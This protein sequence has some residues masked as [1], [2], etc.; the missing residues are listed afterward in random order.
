[1]AAIQGAK[2]MPSWL[3]LILI[4]AALVLLPLV[5]AALVLTSPFIALF[6]VVNALCD[7]KAEI[8]E[9]NLKLRYKLEKTNF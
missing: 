8:H 9:K 5:L 7:L 1:M 6:F 2:K 3:I 4:L